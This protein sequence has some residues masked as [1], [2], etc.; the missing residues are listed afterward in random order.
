MWP[1][2]FLAGAEEVVPSRESAVPR[3]ARGWDPHTNLTQAG[4]LERVL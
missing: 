4:S 1:G 3:P 2:F